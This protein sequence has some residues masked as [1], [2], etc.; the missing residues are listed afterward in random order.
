MCRVESGEDLAGSGLVNRKS[1]AEWRAISGDP[2][3]AVGERLG[4]EPREI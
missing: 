1:G 4:E 3:T 2:L